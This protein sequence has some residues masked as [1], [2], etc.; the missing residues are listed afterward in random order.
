MDS[1]FV[2]KYVLLSIFMGNI[3]VVFDACDFNGIW[4]GDVFVVSFDLRKNL[5]GM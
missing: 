4:M 5:A 3:C 2:V 1:V